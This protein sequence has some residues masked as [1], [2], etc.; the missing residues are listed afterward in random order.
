MQQQCYKDMHCQHSA[1]FQAV[2]SRAQQTG[3]KCLHVKSEIYFRVSRNLNFQ[4]AVAICKQ[5]RMEN[6][7][8]FKKRSKIWR[9]RDNKD[10]FV[11]YLMKTIKE[12]YFSKCFICKYTWHWDIVDRNF[13]NHCSWEM[14]QKELATIVETG[15]YFLW[16]YNTCMVNQTKCKMSL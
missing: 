14:F 9:R 4:S 11:I 1:L 5:T 2:R 15:K 16:R 13:Q 12:R 8:I 7:E 3:R 6:L 10:I